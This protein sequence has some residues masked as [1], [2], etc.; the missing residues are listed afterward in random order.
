M[1]TLSGQKST[2][3][4]LYYWS[5]C[6]ACSCDWGAGMEGLERAAGAQLDS[7]GVVWEV[8]GQAAGLFTAGCC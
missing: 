2:E 1:A 3:A 4:F 7:Q 8:A 5:W 6:R